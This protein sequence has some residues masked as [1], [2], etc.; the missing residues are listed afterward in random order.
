MTVE[1]K[2]LKEAE[3]SFKVQTPKAKKHYSSGN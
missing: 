2:V 3:K 1:V